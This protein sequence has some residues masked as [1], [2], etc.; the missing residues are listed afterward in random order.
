MK[1]NISLYYLAKLFYFPTF[2][3]AFIFIYLTEFR[4]LNEVSALTLLGLQEFLLIFLEIPTGAVADR[5]S[6]KFSCALGNI[7]I[8]LPL[9]LL[10][11][12]NGY[13]QF[14][15]IFVVK[16]IGRALTSGADKSILY[17]TLV[18]LDLTKDYRKIVTRSF[19]LAFG[20]AAISIYIGGLFVK[21]GHIEWTFY[22]SLPFAMVTSIAFLLMKEPEVT[23]KAI[24]M[25]ESNYLRH[26][27]QALRYTFTTKR[28]F[29]LILF[30]SVADGIAV[31]LKW[32]YTPVFTAI[33]LDIAAIGGITANLYVV[34]SFSAGTVE[35]IVDKFDPLPTVRYSAFV[36]MSVFAVMAVYLGF[37][38]VVV[39][40]VVISIAIAAMIVSAETLIQEQ[41]SSHHR[42]TVL[43]SINL[44]SSVIATGSLM[45]F[46]F[47]QTYANVRASLLSISLLFGITWVVVKKFQKKTT[48]K[49]LV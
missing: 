22:A 5:I 2:W 25:Q 39:G 11:F 7:L 20:F 37:I 34:K 42:A 28:I 33:N 29:A 48:E 49:L 38:P 19:A 45:I 6:R 40:F 4:G 32:F 30:L 3:L 41:V 46:G 44:V 27:G 35:K 15:L 8:F 12:A 23:K 10:P 18:D 31:Q 14:V 13:W 17:D 24:K 43:S 1:K 16:A 26:I 9:A 36:L 21:Y 47:L